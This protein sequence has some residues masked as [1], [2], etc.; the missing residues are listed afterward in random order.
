MDLFKYKNSSYLN[1]QPLSTRLRPVN[2]LSVLGQ[3]HLLGKNQLLNQGYR[4]YD[5]S[6]FESLYSKEDG[7]QF[8]SEIL[9]KNGFFNDFKKVT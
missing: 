2:V 3:E 1:K 5:I 7:Y 9:L 6:M 4:L 8:E